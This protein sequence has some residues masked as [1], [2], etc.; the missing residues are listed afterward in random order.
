MVTLASNL[1]PTPGQAGAG[2]LCRSKS[3]ERSHGRRG[4]GV[5]RN[6]SSHRTSDGLAHWTPR[7]GEAV[8]AAST[9]ASCDSAEK[10]WAVAE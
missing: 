7:A 4:S 10:T 5:K 2:Y 8:R 1:A 9:Y 3:I 6:Q